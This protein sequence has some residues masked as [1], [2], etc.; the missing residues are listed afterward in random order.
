MTAAEQAMSGTLVALAIFASTFGGALAGMLL[1]RRLEHDLLNADTRDTVKIT[2]GLVGSM[3]A[4]VLGLVTASAKSSYD[5]VDSTVK[6]TSVALLALDRGLAR[7]GPEAAELRGQLQRS[8]AHRVDRIWPESRAPGA[9]P[10]D[11]PD[12]PAS[13]FEHFADRVGALA[14]D[15][16]SHRAL[17]SRAVE[18]GEQL[19]E[20][21]W[22]IVSQASTPVPVAFL[23]IIGFW[24]TV[25]FCSFGLF[26]PVNGTTVAALFVGAVSVAAALFLVLELGTPFEGVVKVSGDPMRRAIGLLGR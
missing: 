7:Y 13:V 25:T 23:L 1:R 19:L 26:A 18:L 2:M 9:A 11:P 16:E 20:Q 14:A 6:R 4:L 21:R 8:V 3:T 17:R 24:L 22:L 10:D 12:V 5:E 15:N